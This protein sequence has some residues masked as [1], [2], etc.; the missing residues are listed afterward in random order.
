MGSSIGTILRI[1]RLPSLVI[2]EI[3]NVM[4]NELMPPN[5]IQGVCALEVSLTFQAAYITIS[6]GSRAVNRSHYLYVVLFSKM[7]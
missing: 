5:Y 2:L 1:I 7:L 6:T 3:S 4:L